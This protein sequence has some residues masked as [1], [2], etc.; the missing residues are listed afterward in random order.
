MSGP[1]DLETSFA[2]LVDQCGEIVLI[3][4]ADGEAGILE[5]KRY[6]ADVIGYDRD[7]LRVARNQR[8]PDCPR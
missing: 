2:L 4:V 6:A 1:F 3:G 8:G 5:L 7:D